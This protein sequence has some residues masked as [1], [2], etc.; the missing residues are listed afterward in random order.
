M[1]T[2]CDE[3][4]FFARNA[5]ETQSFFLNTVAISCEPLLS[6]LLFFLYFSLRLFFSAS[7]RALRD[8]INFRWKRTS[9]QYET[10]CKLRP[11]VFM[12]ALR[13]LCLQPAKPYSAHCTAQTAA[14]KVSFARP[15]RLLREIVFYLHFLRAL[16]LCVMH[17]Y[18]SL[19]SSLTRR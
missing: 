19:A 8:A 9:S 6:V 14:F 4:L 18:F 3:P 17:P 2:R 15:L 13:L 5:A 11:F 16:R 7:L 12:R 10:L 1:R